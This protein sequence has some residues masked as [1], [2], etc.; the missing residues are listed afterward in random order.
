MCEFESSEE[1]R[2]HVAQIALIANN[3]VPQF[4]VTFLDTSGTSNVR[5]LYL[6]VFID[7]QNHVPNEKITA[8]YEVRLHIV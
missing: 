7:T 6:P 3:R 1:T 5:E 2:A 8:I 4:F